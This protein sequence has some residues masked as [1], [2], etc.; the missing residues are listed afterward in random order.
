MKWH[1]V[2]D[3]GK[4]ALSGGHLFIWVAG[5]R[6][7]KDWR[8]NFDLRR[9]RLSDGAWVCRREHEEALEVLQ[10]IRDA[11]VEFESIEA[12]TIIGFSK[13]GATAQILAY[14]LF[15]FAPHITLMLYA[16]K[17]AGNRRF[18]RQLRHRTDMILAIAYRGDIVPFLPPWPFRNPKHS[19]QGR[20]RW[21]WNA[22]LLAKK[23]AA[24]ARHRMRKE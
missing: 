18:L 16:S 2:P 5:T 7:W 15:P 23:D 3:I 1:S 14:K 19:R 20:L 11:E 9:D 22:H 17:R 13:G 4:W 6:G 21:Q 24:K 12:V 8:D 10:V